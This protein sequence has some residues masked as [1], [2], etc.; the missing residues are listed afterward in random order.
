M[1]VKKVSII[2]NYSLTS[3]AKSLHKTHNGRQDSE[4]SR[5]LGGSRMSG[6]RWFA[7]ETNPREEQTAEKEIRA[8][9]YRVY[10]PTA[11]VRKRPY[12]AGVQLGKLVEIEVPMFGGY[13]FAEF[14]R[15][16]TPW[17]PI[18]YC[19]GVRRLLTTS[20]G[21]PLPVELGLVERLIA[22]EKDRLKLPSHVLSRIAR[23]ALCKIDHDHPTMPG[24]LGECV[25]CDGLVTVLEIAM[26]GRPVN[27]TL[28]R[29]SVIGVDE[30][31]EGEAEK[32]R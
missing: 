10:L 13:L 8:K 15:D 26:F 27:V 28:K 6:L 9:G 1:F 12:R 14:D 16:N 29:E 2:E 17:T 31:R 25:S 4:I 21:T 30:E 20:A 23:G 18:R 24:Q 5:I 7:V 11:L 3:G 32:M 19:R 22:S